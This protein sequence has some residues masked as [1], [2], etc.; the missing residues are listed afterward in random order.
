[1][2]NMMNHGK[3]TTEG[4]AKIVYIT[5]LISIVFSIVGLVGLVIAYVNRGDAPNWLRSHYQFQI[6]TFWIGLLYAF[7]GFVLTYILIG[8]L[9]L[10]FCVIWMII[11]CVKGMK[12]LEQKEA[13]PDPMSWMF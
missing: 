1:M 13:H 6:R 4:N 7:I 12:Y 3:P 5:Y 8:F 9:V 10:L 11:R 2:N